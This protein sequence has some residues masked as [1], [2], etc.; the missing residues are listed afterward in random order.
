MGLEIKDAVEKGVDPSKSLKRKR[1]QQDQLEVQ[2]AREELEKKK[3]EDEEKRLMEQTVLVTHPYT[4]EQMML[5]HA[6]RVQF[7]QDLQHM[8][9]DQFPPKGTG[10]GS[11]GSSTPP[12]PPAGF[13]PHMPQHMGYG[14]YGTPGTPGAPVAP[15]TL[16]VLS[17]SGN[18]ENTAP[19]SFAFGGKSA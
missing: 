11:M 15:A 14:P 6:Q 16:P 12:I 13:P 10:K 9:A 5:N 8:R 3:K 18:P 19:G 17:G 1:E 4:G 2:R 7:F